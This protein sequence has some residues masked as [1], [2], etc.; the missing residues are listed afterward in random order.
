M[1]KEEA[2]NKILALI[3]AGKTVKEACD[4][5]GIG[6]S[7]YYGWKGSRIAAKNR[8]KKVTHQTI[9]IPTDDSRSKIERARLLLGL[10]LEE[11][12]R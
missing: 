6:F 11:L 2:M 4:Q 7:T 5:V 12:N 1:N 9:V 8:K 3:K 10:A